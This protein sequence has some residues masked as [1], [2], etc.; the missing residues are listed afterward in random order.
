[1]IRHAPCAILSA[2][3]KSMFYSYACASLRLRTVTFRRLYF[4]SSIES[5]RTLLV[6]IA[7]E[8]ACCI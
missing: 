6:Y 8:A 1:M 3:P 5:M 7:Q 4:M 2:H